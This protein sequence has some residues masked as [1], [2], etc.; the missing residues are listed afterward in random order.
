M[1]KL[2]EAKGK[3]EGYF[4][5][6]SIISFAEIFALGML[7]ILSISIGKRFYEMRDELIFR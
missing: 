5:E 2:S 4:F 7:I 3:S 6:R 1:F